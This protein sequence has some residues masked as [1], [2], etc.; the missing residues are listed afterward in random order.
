[1]LNNQ[2]YVQLLLGLEMGALV[3]TKD[4][5]LACGVV[6]L[7]TLVWFVW[8]CLLFVTVTF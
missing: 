4:D 7:F 3:L 8:F 5:R 1:M 2:F 6:T